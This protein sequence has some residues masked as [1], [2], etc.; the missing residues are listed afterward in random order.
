MRQMAIMLTRKIIIGAA[1]LLAGTVGVGARSEV[2]KASYYASKSRTADGGR[3]GSLTAAH[4]TLPLG[5][6]ARVTN[7]ANHRSVEVTVND[8]DPF[9]GGRVI[10]V[11]PQAAKELGI[12]AAGVAPVEV[13]PAP[14]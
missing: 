12:R 8:R 14:K 11:L 1:V 2:G 10:D 13:K 6:K 5:S 3:V 4:R 7:L 9:T